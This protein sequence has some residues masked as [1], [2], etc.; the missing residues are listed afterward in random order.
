MDKQKAVA[1]YRQAAELGSLSAQCNLGYC[2]YAGIG[3]RIDD[4][5]AVK[6]FRMA[7]AQDYPRALFL[8]GRCYEQGRGVKADLNEARRLYQQADAAGFEDAADALKH[9]DAGKN[10]GSPKKEK[11]SGGLLGFLKRK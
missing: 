8:L 2:F 3:T 5:E 6:W 4:D 1:L 7:A 9:L 10:P 11:R